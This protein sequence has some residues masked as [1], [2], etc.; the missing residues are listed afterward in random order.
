MVPVIWNG[1]NWEITN[2]DSGVWYDYS[3]DAKKWANVM[4]QDGLQIASDGKTVQ[5]FGSMFAWI[6]RYMYKIS[7]GYHGTNSNE[8]EIK[9]LKVHIRYSN[10]QFVC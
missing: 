8:I 6:P 10:R 5:S 4:L 2:K 7:E 9:F 1:T 3:E